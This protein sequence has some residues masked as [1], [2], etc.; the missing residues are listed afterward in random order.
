M[1]LLSI[2]SMLYGKKGEWHL[3]CMEKLDVPYIG[4]RK[5]Q[6]VLRQ[7]VAFGSNMLDKQHIAKEFLWLYNKKYSM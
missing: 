5:G 1:L 2:N 4:S 7:R 3:Q 6:Y